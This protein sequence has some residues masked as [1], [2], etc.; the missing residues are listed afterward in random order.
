LNRCT[1]RTLGV[2]LVLLVVGSI[3][4]GCDAGMEPDDATFCD[5]VPVT[6][7]DNFGAGFI[8]QNCR[9]CHGENSVDRQGAPDDVILQ[10]RE[11]VLAWKDLIVVQAG[12]DDPQMPPIGGGERYDRYLLEVWL[13]CWEE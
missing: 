11:D 2:A 5:G 1:L 8:T 3:L 4:N 9:T 10:D 12:V 13:R 6:T 7:W